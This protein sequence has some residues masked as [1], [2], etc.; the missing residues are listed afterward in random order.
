ML[1]GKYEEMRPSQ[2][3]A[4]LAETATAYIAWGSL[5]W[6]G[7]QGP[8][9][10]DTLKA[11]ELCLRCAEQTGGVVLPPIYAGFQTMKPH[12][13]FK[14]TIEIRRPTVMD[15]LE[16]HLDQLADEGFKFLVI[17]M[18]HYGGLH[19]DA[20]R[21]TVEW[22]EH[23][24]KGMKVWAI[25][26]YEPV[27]DDGIRGDHAGK[28][29]TSLVMYLRPG[30]VD[31][32]EL[33]AEGCLDIKQHGISGEDARESTVENGKRLAELIVQRVVEGVRERRD[34]GPR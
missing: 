25:P 13:G 7:R 5:E 22:W 30:L 23:N 17:M 29:E 12:A 4:V 1:W 8:I 28:Y 26:D 3:E 2:I 31:L 21:K 10:V 20:I 14:H 18:G 16:Q 27:L 19:V 24:H 15:L 9:G 32:S 33:P 6:H 34:K 11:Y